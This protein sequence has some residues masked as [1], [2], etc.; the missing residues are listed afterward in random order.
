MPVDLQS[1]LHFPTQS[2]IWHIQV[3]VHFA[4]QPPPAQCNVDMPLPPWSSV[5]APA[6]HWSVAERLPR[7]LNAHPGEV[8]SD[9]CPDLDPTQF[10]GDV[11]VGRSAVA[12]T[13]RFR[14]AIDD[15]A[16][17]PSFLPT[18][19]VPSV[20]ARCGDAMTWFD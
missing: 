16:P 3:P 4:E 14:G 9:P 15:L 7:C 11:F 1:T 8:A 2:T 10:S 6:G 19:F 5:H 18:G 12:D 20:F 17:G 13:S